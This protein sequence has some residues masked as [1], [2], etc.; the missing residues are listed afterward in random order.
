[1]THSLSSIGWPRV[2]TAALAVVGVSFLALM[3][4]IAGYAFV[5]AF[6]VGGA[7]DQVAINHFAARISP[8]LLPWLEMLLTFVVSLI[9][10]RR[11]EAGSMVQGI[12]IGAFAG[13]LSLAVTLA[14]GGRL[15]LHSLAFLAA[16]VG[17][18][19]LGS[20]VGQRKTGST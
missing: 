10:A 20:F 18:A 11:A 14:F 7:P 15:G 16:L 8:R 1:M 4:L 5:L 12:C 2:L 9:V 13:L 17:L 19:W 6:E 3:I